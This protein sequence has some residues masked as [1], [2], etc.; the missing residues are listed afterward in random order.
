M[1]TI[2]ETTCGGTVLCRCTACAGSG[3]TVQSLDAACRS[4]FAACTACDGTGTVERDCQ[5]QDLTITLDGLHVHGCGGGVTYEVLDAQRCPA[6]G[7]VPD[8]E[9]V[10][11]AVAAYLEEAQ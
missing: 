5:V 8:R 3:E 2:L 6:C 11:R 7:W 4:F 10:R 1:V 9:D